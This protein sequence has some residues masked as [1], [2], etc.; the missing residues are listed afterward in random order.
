MRAA[1]VD[2]LPEVGAAAAA[3]R[4][5]DADDGDSSAPVTPSAP[6]ADSR[7]PDPLRCMLLL[8]AELSAPGA[9]PLVSMSFPGAMAPALLSAAAW[10]GDPCNPQRDS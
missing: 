6:A 7:R 3:G 5:A 9:A 4:D 2:G 10:A 1:A 8:D